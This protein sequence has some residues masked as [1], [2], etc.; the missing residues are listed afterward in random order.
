VYLC[1]LCGYENKQRLFPYTA[2]TDFVDCAVQ[3]GFLNIIQVNLSSKYKLVIANLFP[4]IW[5]T[6]V[7][8]YTQ[9]RPLINVHDCVKNKW[10]DSLQFSL[11]VLLISLLNISSFGDRPSLFTD[12]KSM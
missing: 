4:Y 11:H 5:H 8:T 9:S 1:V 2:L 6:V 10:K 12:I 3:A 7:A